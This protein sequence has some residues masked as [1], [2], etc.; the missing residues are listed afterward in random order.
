MVGT[1]GEGLS[2]PACVPQVNEEAFEDFFSISDQT[3]G[4][5]AVAAQQ[6]PYA[7]ATR[8][9]ARAAAV[10]VVDV[11]EAVGRPDSPGGSLTPGTDAALIFKHGVV[12]LLGDAVL[13]LSMM[14]TLAIP[15]GRVPGGRGSR[16][17]LAVAFTVLGLV[18]PKSGLAPPTVAVAPVLVEDDFDFFQASSTPGSAMFGVQV[19]KPVVGAELSSASPSRSGPV[20]LDGDQ[21]AA[22]AF[23]P[24]VLL[25]DV[26]QAVLIPP[27]S[28]ALAEVDGLT[29]DPST[30]D[31]CLGS[32]AGEIPASAVTEAVGHLAVG[33]APAPS[34][35][36]RKD[37]T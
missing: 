24:P 11:E 32:D 19:A 6:P 15:V 9:A 31:G 25:I 10:V 37:C 4:G 29:L 14:G 12:V 22:T 3:Q 23:R 33:C 17:F 34:L 1:S 21:S 13:G 18:L 26:C 28:V 2:A 8:G 27:G 30:L 5:V 20:Q 7:P 36:H 16:S 35:S